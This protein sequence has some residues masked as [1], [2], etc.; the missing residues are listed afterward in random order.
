MDY[1]NICKEH[2]NSTNSRSHKPEK[3][4]SSFWMHEPEKIFS[5]LNLKEGNYFL[6]I[7]CG[8]GDYSLHASSL[9]K[10]VGKIYALDIQEELIG[11]INK[12]ANSNGLTNITAEVYDITTPLN[13]ENKSIDVCFISTVL[14][15]LDLKK[16]GNKLFSEIRR[17]LKDNGHLFIIECKKGDCSFGPPQNMRISPEELE[18]MINPNGFQT[19]NLMDL[20]FNYMIQFKLKKNDKMG[21]H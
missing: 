21:I 8:K 7:G 3:G 20:G 9:V 12:K 18:D 6:D 10:D 16:Y 15:S 17:V 5:A 2:I 1:N 4:P 13:L 11:N 19:I 14:H